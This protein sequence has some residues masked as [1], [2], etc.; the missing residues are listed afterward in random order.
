MVRET[1][2][3]PEGGVDSYPLSPMQQG[4]LFHRFQG[5]AAG[6]DVEQVIGE[7]HEP[8]RAVEFE[9]AWNEVVERHAALRTGFF[10]ENGEEPRQV[11]YPA[12]RVR[13]DFYHAEFGSEQEARL[14]L[15]EYLSADRSAG[16]PRL[17]PSLLRIA[18]LRGGPEHFWFVATYHHLALDARAM[19]VMFKEALDLHDALAEGRTLELPTPRPYRAYIDW[20]KTHDLNRA[21]SF[22]REELRGFAAPTALPLARPTPAPSAPEAVAGELAF[23]LAPAAWAQLRAAAQKHEVTLNTLVQAAWAIV[24]GR[25]AGEDEVVFGALRACR[26]IPVDG[27]A[28][29]IGLFI[30]TVPLRVPVAADLEIGAWLRRLRQ[31]WVALRDYEHTPL[32]KVQQWSDVPPGRALFDTIVSYQEPAWDAALTALGGRWATRRFDIRAQP[33]YPL[34][35][36]V[37]GGATL[38]V[39]FIYDCARYSDEAIARLMGHYRVVLEA[40]AAD[41]TA[42]VRDLPLLTPGELQ[43]VLVTWNQTL[44]EYPRE[45]CVHSCVEQHAAAEPTRIAITDSANALTYGEFNARANRLAHRLITL[46]VKA[47]EPVAVCMERSAEMMVA[48]LAVLKAGGAFVPLD[49]AYPPERLAFQLQDCA[50]RVVLTQPRMRSVLPTL[51]STLPVLD[52][53]ADGSGFAE[54]SDANPALRVQAGSLAYVIYTSG[55]TGQPKGVQI[56]HRSLLNLVTWHQRRYGVTAADRAAHLASPAFDASVWEIW[57]YLATGASVH[58]PEDETRLSPALLW[59]WMADKKISIAFMPTPLAE[60]ALAEPWPEGMVLRALLTGGDK[61]K[62]RPPAGFAC[63]LVNHY[64]PTES[65]VVATCAVVGQRASANGTP[66]IGAPIA[67]TQTYVLDR[68]LR[69]VPVG[70]AG[71]LFIGGESLARG[72]LRRP[73]LTAEK[74]LRVVLPQDRRERR[75]Y[76]TGDLVRWTPQGELEFLGRLDG[77]VKV[78]GCRIELGEIEA[79]LQR[80]PA[81]RDS[82]VLARPD[83]RGQTQLVAYVVAAADGTAGTESE[84]IDFLRAKLPAYMVP[85]AIVPLYHWPLTPNGKIDRKALPA[86][87]PRNGEGRGPFAAPSGAVE[88]AVAKVWADVLGCPPVGRADNFFDLGGH[89]LLAAQAVTRLNAVLAARVSVRALFDQPTL[90]AFA[91]EVELRI[92]NDPTARSPIHRVKR[93]AAARSELELVQPN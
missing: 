69:P 90:A 93:R 57:P 52:V 66:S 30:N 37:L 59:R 71:E 87:A 55:S 42:K 9:K 83:E 12:A 64:G 58:V 16:F 20:L 49:P 29:M 78:R 47:D 27:A 15:E 18:L 44:S 28:T 24:L 72:Y 54:E 43:D 91:R 23:R 50:A 63:A 17:T 39:K 35:L 65:T 51:S 74:F 73:E 1:K 40:L 8:V 6:V 84:L 4:M 10:W 62:Q 21:E 81:G 7:L 88:Q 2:L 3:T 48:W 61:L 5:G 34:A 82:V 80:H 32:M 11:V 22:W 13:L 68:E 25:H 89:S 92:G 70:V 19:T 31:T 67:N 75:L 86:P 14:G 77:Q 53:P 60:A 56:E 76:R 33:N 38:T 46:G 45:Q 85:A 41:R 26:K 36:E 79:T